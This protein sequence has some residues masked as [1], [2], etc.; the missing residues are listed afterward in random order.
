MFLRCTT[1]T[2]SITMSILEVLHLVHHAS[3]HPLFTTFPMIHHA[4][5][6][7]RPY[8]VT[9]SL[10]PLEWPSLK[11]CSLI[12]SFRMM[13]CWQLVWT[14]MMYGSQ[15]GLVYLIPSWAHLFLNCS[16]LRGLGPSDPSLI[17]AKRDKDYEITIFIPSLSSNPQKCYIQCL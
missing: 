8:L 16:V 10:P 11:L 1:R 4:T 7:L 9:P 3:P 17:R 15:F 12:N 2:W 6:L 5:T 14:S 13:P